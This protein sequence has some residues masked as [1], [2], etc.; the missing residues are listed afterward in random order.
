MSAPFFR[1][2][3]NPYAPVVVDDLLDGVNEWR[4][5]SE[6]VRLTFKALSDVV[7]AQGL[8]LSKFEQQLALKANKQEVNT[9]LALKANIS[10]V[11]RSMTEV[12]RAM[13]QKMTMQDVKML[14]ADKVSKSE[15]YSAAGRPD[16]TMGV[17]QALG[18]I[19][20]EIELLKNSVVS[21]KDLQEVYDVCATKVQLA[22]VEE[23]LHN[24]ANKQ[25]VA[26]ALHRKANKSEVDG[27]VDY[28]TELD[29]LRNLLDTKVNFS[30]YERLVKEVAMKADSV[31]LERL[32][33]RESSSSAR[34]E[35]EIAELRAQQLHRSNEASLAMQVDSILSTAKSEADRMY[36]TLYTMLGKKAEVRDFDRVSQLLAKKADTENISQVLEE[37]RK[38]I[39]Q[40]FSSIA[41]E[42]R[43]D[44]YSSSE[45]QEERLFKVENRLRELS[46][47][48]EQVMKK[49]H[50]SLETLR[51]DHERLSS[52]FS[53][54]RANKASEISDLKRRIDQKPDSTDLGRSVSSALQ[55]H[56]SLA[57]EIKRDF[58]L[59]LEKVEREL[60]A[61][62]S[63][64]ADF[65]EIKLFIDDKLEEHR[66]DHSEASHF[67]GLIKNLQLELEKHIAATKEA[68]E[69]LYKSN[70]LKANIK[71][72][73][74]LLDLKASSD[75]V[76]QA[77]TDLSADLDTKAYSADLNAFTQ[78]QLLV[79]ELLC[80]ENCVGRWIWK[81]GSL[82]ITNAVPWEVQSVNTCPDNFLWEKGQG[83][84]V[85]VAPGLYQV[86]WGFFSKKPPNL[87]LVVNGE[88]V[89]IDSSTSRNHLRHSAGNVAGVGK[90][91]FLALPTR[92][93]VSILYESDEVGEGFLGL[94]KL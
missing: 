80:T 30:S 54:F 36:S 59:T 26:T 16:N 35:L 55:E 63:R 42:V 88:P 64:K 50:D 3:A 2:D 51:S 62:I 32:L 85:A 10:D 29:E 18:E 82:P 27:F 46:V 47:E 65:N 73:C 31:A 5:V 79:N 49:L 60:M 33:T 9:N 94:K 72:V 45:S 8:A 71:D 84:I 25:S 86:F 57:K 77:F 48:H 78:E 41:S 58:S 74:T 14:L 22:E 7:K 38:E 76:R 92:A 34:Q 23:A 83:T 21:Q 6:V 81:S 75:E 19:S 87:Q 40:A 53:D 67:R 12:V 68:L 66:T 13:E 28:K 93:R 56:G 52:H 91:E 90:S 15:L 44:V 24:K 43:K 11:Q 39:S 17:K 69:E 70:L 89:F 61:V 37:F 20:E 1:G 4:S